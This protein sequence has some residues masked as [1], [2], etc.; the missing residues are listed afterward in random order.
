MGFCEP[1]STI[2]QPSNSS[3]GHGAFIGTDSG[4]VASRQEAPA[5]CDRS[6]V[7]RQ[8]QLVDVVARR[9]RQPVDLEL[10]GPVAGIVELVDDEGRG[11]VH[12][13]LGA[14][15]RDDEVG[16]A[17]PRAVAHGD[18]EREGGNGKS[19]RD[20]EKHSP[21][22]TARER[23]DGR[24]GRELGRRPNLDEQVVHTT[25][26][27]ALGRVEIGADEGV[28][29]GRSLAHRNS[30]SSASASRARALLV[31]VFTVPSGIPSTSAISLCESPRQ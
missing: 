25:Q 10:H 20:C 28:E 9:G 15:H 12:G 27:L 24:A 30:P 6:A 3:R 13:G 22:A 1:S 19:G 4:P 26:P 5:E 14:G 29:V 18:A 31:R 23:S 17:C 21:A 7:S 16:R 2:S 8:P 11:R